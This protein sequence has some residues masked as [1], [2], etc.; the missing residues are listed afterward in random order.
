MSVSTKLDTVSWGFSRQ[1]G[2]S[3]T[4]TRGNNILSF[5]QSN[6]K[7]L[8][9]NGNFALSPD[10]CI[11]S[12]QIIHSLSIAGAANDTASIVDCINENH[13]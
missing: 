8:A 13:K 6:L 2:R 1:T 7:N 12:L 9:V 4:A 5:A 10:F 3:T 11:L